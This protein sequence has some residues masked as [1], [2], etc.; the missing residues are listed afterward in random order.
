M[1]DKNALHWGS[2]LLG[3]MLSMGQVYG[4]KNLVGSV[5]M[6][7]ATLLYSPTIFMMAII[8]ATVGTIFGKLQNRKIMI[9]LGI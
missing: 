2:I 4:V 8:G 1:Q 9:I 7:F 5:L 3:I 6:Y